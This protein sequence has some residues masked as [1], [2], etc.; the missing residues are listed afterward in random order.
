MNYLAELKQRR[1]NIPKAME[2]Y[3]YF[4]NRLVDIRTSDKNEQVTITDAPDNGMRVFIQKITKEG[5]LGDTLLNMVYKPEITQE[6]RLFISGGDDH[7]T[8]N[9]A[10]LLPP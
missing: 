7:V 6:I 10:R 4:I 1:D 8:I 2:E 5:K 3:Y 9:T